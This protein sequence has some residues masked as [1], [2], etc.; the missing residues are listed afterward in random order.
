MK[1]PLSWKRRLL[2]ALT[3][4]AAL[5]ASALAVATRLALRPLPVDLEE[6]ITATGKSI[7]LDRRGLRLNVTYENDWNLHDQAGIHEVPEFLQQAFLLSED[8]RFFTHNGV[9]W[10]A[11]LNAARQNLLAGGVV[12]G[13][14]TITEQVVR[15]L[16]PRPRTLWS[17]WLEGF[18]AGI[19]EKRFSKLELL[20]FYLNQVPYRAQRRGV[21]Q[22]AQHYFGRD[23]S[24]LN[25]KEMLA[26]AVLVRSPRWLDPERRPASL[27]R[28]ITSLAE[29]LSLEPDET[30]AILQQKLSLPGP[31]I[32]F[33][34]S[35]FLLYAGNHLGDQPA[36]D[37][38]VH[39]TID[40]ELQV[41]TQKILDNRLRRLH[42][43]RVDNGAVLVVDHERNAILAWVVGYAGRRDRPFNRID[44]VT[45]PRQPGSA[46]KPLLYASAIRKGW[47]A[48]TMLDDSPLEESVGPGLHSYQN[49]SRQHYGLVS[50]REAL[51]NSLNIPAVRAIQYVGTGEFLGFLHELG[52]ISLTGH[53]NVYGD[54]LALGNGELSLFELVQ[55]YTVLAR[56]GDF[57]PLSFVDGETRSSGRQVLSED[58]ASLVADII[59]DPA[60]REK[61]FGWDSVLNLPGQTAVKTGTSSDYRDAWAVGFNDRYTVGVWMGNLDYQAMDG[62]TGA[63]GPAFVLRSV[64]NELNRHRQAR[65]LYFSPSLVR[66]RVCIDSGLPARDECEA[67]DEWFLPGTGPEG[68]G[69]PEETV[70]IRKPGKGLL[71]AM[72]PRIPDHAE[73]FE[74]AVS[75][76][77]NLGSVKWYVNGQLA[78]TTK[79]PTYAWKL[80]RGEFTA[81]AEVSFTNERPP[82]V[83]EEVGFRVK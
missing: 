46:L 72:D 62:I 15:M 40:G 31:T 2:I 53:P 1:R 21:I 38:V 49:Y 37:G 20:E 13:A 11:R 44:A 71:L 55:A 83:T 39:T 25:H 14:S 66:Q 64:F 29:R 73:Y 61:E 27:E 63:G 69:T 52:I 80:S 47:T 18:D 58:I 56:M 34:L 16:H 9:D 77:A 67:R 28:A 41:K 76:I 48:A 43:R 5:S 57:K 68:T 74:F 65:P 3:L 19:L 4:M 81:R 23:L 6:E 8:K 70:R 60:A 75:D 82:V 7:Y 17:R 59:S 78:A 12:R 79:T 36:A 50:L 26:L 51:G 54:G 45:A 32:D 22:A 33:D 30:R 10:L 42:S 24:T 35:H